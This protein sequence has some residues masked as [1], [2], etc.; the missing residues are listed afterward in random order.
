MNRLKTVLMIVGL[1]LLAQVTFAQLRRDVPKLFEEAEAA[2]DEGNYKEAL[3]ILNECIK[4]DPSFMPAY[5]KRGSTR[6]QLNDLAGALT[7]YSIYLEELTEDP[8]ATLAR[9]LLHFRQSHFDLAKLDFQKLLKMK[10]GPTTTI[11]YRQSSFGRGTDLITTVQSG[12]KSSYLNYIGLCETKLNNYRE[13]IIAFDSA[14]RR[15]PREADYYVNRGIARE[16]AGDSLASDDYRKALTIEPDHG[17]AKHNLSVLQSKSG[18][19]QQAETILTDVLESDSS[20]SYAYLQRA[21]QRFEAGY[22]KGALEDYNSVLK[23]EDNDPELFLARGLT[24]E[25]LKDFQGAFSDYTKAID[26]KEDMVKAW[27]NRGNVLLKLNRHNDA[28]EDYSVA[29]TYA[30]DLAAAFYNRG[31]AKYRLK[32]SKEACD[33]IKVA[34]GM[35]FKGDEKTI[36]KICNTPR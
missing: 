30:P 16:A 15:D 20:M 28:I 22:Y 25:K 31:I 6:E 2:H 8:D 26:L 12:G 14:I 1:L 18:N 33:D 7:D 23:I 34:E 24:R 19:K 5:M 21:Q 35:G 3:R 9:G 36:Q 27:V 32:L 17:I 11:L 4:I 10:T 13:A 29:I